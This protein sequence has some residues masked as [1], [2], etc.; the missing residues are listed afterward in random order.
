MIAI[1]DT[2]PWVALIDRSETR[3][4]ECVKWLKNFSGSL[5]S[6]EAVLTEVLYLLN[7]SITAQ[8]AALDFVLKSVIE[9]V[10]SSTE[11]LKKIKS[12]MKK[13]A[14]L[15]MDFA[16]ASIVCLASETG[17]Q[18]IVTFDKKDF[19]IYRLPKKKSFSI[20]P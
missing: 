4:A 11:S 6:T 9:I 20:I 16:D 13:Y 15:P 5:Y 17:M 19:A 12:L 3:H 7:F 14:D 18:N 8:C 10:P 2:G 1:L